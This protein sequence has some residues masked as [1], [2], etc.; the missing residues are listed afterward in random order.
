LVVRDE[1]GAWPK[2][3]IPAVG[4]VVAEH[5]NGFGRHHSSQRPATL[6]ISSGAVA[7]DVR[8]FDSLSIDFEM[9]AG[10][11]FHLVSRDGNHPLDEGF[12]G[13]LLHAGNAT[14]DRQ[15]GDETAQRADGVVLLQGWIEGLGCSKHHDFASFGRTGAVSEFF[16]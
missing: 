5:E 3:T 13:W 1:V 6:A 16:H 10:V 14:N 4:P 12:A 8:L 11:H 9:P 7:V 2:T 15:S